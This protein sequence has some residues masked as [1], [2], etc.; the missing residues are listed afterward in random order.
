MKLLIYGVYDDNNLGDDYMML[1]INQYLNEKN[2]DCVFIKRNLENNNY[3]NVNKLVYL[4]NPFIYRCSGKLIKIKKTI[5]I[6]KWMFT[7]KDVQEYDALIFMGGG[8]T[9]EQFGNINL[10]KMLLWK[11]KF[12]RLKKN[13]Y[14]TGQTIGPAKKI[15]S[16]FL[17]KSLYSNVKKVHVREKYS[18]NYIKE[19]DIEGE[20]IGDDA[21]LDK[22]ENKKFVK[23]DLM[24]INYKCFKDYNEER[25]FTK[26]IIDFYNKNQLKILIIPF[27]SQEKYEEYKVNYKLYQILKENNVDVEFKVENDI[28][29]FENILKKS[30]YVIGSAY[31]S[32]V[33]GLKYGNIV[34]SVYKGDYYK[35]KMTGILDWYDLN[36]S[37]IPF[38]S[39]SVQKIEEIIKCTPKNIDQIQE[40]TNK[41][42]KSVNNGWQLIIDNVKENKHI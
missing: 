38:E 7:S 6:L 5:N 41:L 35:I 21:F 42:I 32:I 23:E 12:K 16:K 20:L 33:L 30:K 4:D 10:I 11:I 8:Y 26:S 2:I 28:N 39:L 18:L 19:N 36:T 15:F 31:H 40:N 37:A 24:V 14:F 13:I 34:I 29:K 22:I 9:N 27:R 17:L 3:F 1:K 25:L